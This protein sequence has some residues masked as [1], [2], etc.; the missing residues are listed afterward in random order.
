MRDVEFQPHV[1][2]RMI[3]LGLRCVSGGCWRDSL[4]APTRVRSLPPCGGGLGRGVAQQ[5]VPVVVDARRTVSARENPS[6]APPSLTLPHK[7]GGNGE[8]A[9]VDRL[10]WL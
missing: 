9:A 4:F 1:I 7:G 10:D 6:V 5:T 2:L 8:S 3:R